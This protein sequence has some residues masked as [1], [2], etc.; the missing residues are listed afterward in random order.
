MQEESE[1]VMAGVLL[2][3]IEEAEG[4]VL[5]RKKRKRNCV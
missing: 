1:E 3:V 4:R 2:K 5:K